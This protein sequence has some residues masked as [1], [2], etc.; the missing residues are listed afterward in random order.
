MR[1]AQQVAVITGA[2]SGIGW[3]LAHE[4]ARQGASVG[5]IA[6]R[7]DQLARLADEIRQAG[8]KAEYA[9]ADVADRAGLHAAIQTVTAALGPVDLLVANAGVGAPTTLAPM[10]IGDF[11]KMYRVNVFGV[12][13]AIEAVAPAMIA[14]KK[15]HIAAVS[16]LAG[17]KGLPG[18]WGYSSSKAAVNN[19]MD[20]LRI[21]VRRHGITVTNICPGFIRT[22]MTAKNDFWMPFLMGPDEAARRIAWA[23]A[24][25]RKVYN[26]PWPMSLFMGIVARLPDWI[27]D[28]VMNRYNENP[29]WPD[30]P[31]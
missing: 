19:L 27:V 3:A 26:F 20:G 1:F 25:R 18:E 17:Y 13:Y 10:N 4:L 31:L 24:R 22:P 9:A 15:G 29:P 12:V 30:A 16:S 11:E 21:Q 5:L 14:R 23:L 28:R 8:G 7:A 2:S 6:R